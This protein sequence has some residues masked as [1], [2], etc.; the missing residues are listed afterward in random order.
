MCVW[1][2]GGGGGGWKIIVFG[3]GYF[4]HLRSEL[5]SFYLFI[6]QLYLYTIEFTMS[7]IFLWAKFGPGFF[8]NPQPHK[9]QM[10][11]P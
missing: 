3:P 8:L 2:G 1:G 10:I 6:I 4:F 7:W 5:L 9:N 11:A